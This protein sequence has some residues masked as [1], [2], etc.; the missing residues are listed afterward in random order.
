MSSSNTSFFG[1]HAALDVSRRF[2]EMCRLYAV[3]VGLP[4]TATVAAVIDEA[5]KEDRTL[6]LRVTGSY[7]PDH[8]SWAYNSG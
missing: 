2:A 4:A 5:V 8:V 6:E 1:G 7:E 3:E